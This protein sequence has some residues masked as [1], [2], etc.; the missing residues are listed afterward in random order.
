MGFHL[1]APIEIEQKQK[2][3]KSSNFTM[4]E[5]GRGMRHCCV[6][7]VTRVYKLH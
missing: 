5:G 2:K 6:Q 4:S 3:E 7:F 1:K